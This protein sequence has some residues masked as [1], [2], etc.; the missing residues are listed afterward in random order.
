[1]V[2]FAASWA[3]YGHAAVVARKGLGK[4]FEQKDLPRTLGA[5]RL[6]YGGQATFGPSK[7]VVKPR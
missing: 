1:M 2:V 6:G 7:V 5:A 4:S 3:G